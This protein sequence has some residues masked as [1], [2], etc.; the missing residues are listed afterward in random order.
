MLMIVLILSATSALSV[1]FLIVLVFRLKRLKRIYNDENNFR[2]M[3]ENSIDGFVLADE[4]G[5]IIEWNR[6]AERIT[7]LKREG[8]IG[9]EFWSVQSEIISKPDNDTDISLQLRQ[10]VLEFLRAGQLTSENQPLEYEITTP[11][12][13]KRFVQEL[14]FPVLTGKGFMMGSVTRDISE[15]GK[16]ENALRQI[17]LFDELTGL[18]NRRGFILLADQQLKLCSR[19]G[20]D[21]LLFFADLDNMKWINDNLG[22]NEG[23]RALIDTANILRDTFRE[24]DII[25]RLG[26]DEFAVVAVGFSRDSVDMLKERFDKN[27]LRLNNNHGRKYDLSVSMG[28][29]SSDEAENMGIE[30]MIKI[31]DERMYLMK[32]NRKQ[33]L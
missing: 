11:D 17:A 22:H 28:F 4:S 29:V 13:K 27:L 8:V 1:F 23:D 9:R 12:G 18:Y 5:R 6:G 14:V 31:A 16:I 24:A 3:I 30:K 19:K 25:A 21:L 2:L 20:D 26:G 32:H 10:T 7:G 33:S 15:L